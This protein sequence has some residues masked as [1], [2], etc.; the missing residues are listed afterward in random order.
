MVKEAK[1]LNNKERTMN[2]NNVRI[3][4]RMGDIVKMK[5]DALVNPANTELKMGG[6]LALT[7]RRKGGRKIEEQAKEF[8]PIK[9]GQSVITWAG[10]L[11]VKFI[12]HSATMGMDFKTNQEI[13]SK[14]I[15]SAL[16]LA[17]EKKIETIL[18]PALGCGVGKFPIREAGKIMAEEVINHI[19]SKTSL[20]KISFVL[21]T[22][23]VYQ[24][25]KESFQNHAE[26]ILRKLSKIPIPTV[27]AII[28]IE[29]NKIILIK[30]NNPPYGWALPGGFVGYNESLE[31][32]VMREVE[33]ETSL[34]VTDLKQFHTYSEPGR[35]PRFHT[36]STVFIVKT[37][38]SPF[39][40]SDA[41]S[42]KIIDLKKLPPKRE[43]AFD[44]WQIIRDWLKSRFK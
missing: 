7:I 34:K 36:V 27:D 43:F 10:K 17:N 19:H 4:F 31:E 39:A 35:D 30:R 8:A 12:I 6:G 14:A 23:T 21:H 9:L 28:E 3:E 40:K 22:Q 42:F 11:P 32:C 13:I 26:Y 1:W 24:A 25:F 33:E 38:G 5:A 29:K 16:D 37:K 18:I 15:S 20:Q 41:K 44:H 2:I